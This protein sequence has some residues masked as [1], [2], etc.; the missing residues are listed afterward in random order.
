MLVNLAHN[1]R[2]DELNT[3]KLYVTGDPRD[4]CSIPKRRLEEI[5]DASELWEALEEQELLADTAEGLQFLLAMITTACPGRQDQVTLIAAHAAMCGI[6]LQNVP[7]SNNFGG[8]G[9]QIKQS[10]TILIIIYRVVGKF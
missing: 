3:L 6:K 5:R 2:A 8:N 10:M 9:V 1:V 4:P 7:F